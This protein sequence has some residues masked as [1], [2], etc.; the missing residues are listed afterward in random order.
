MQLGARCPFQRTRL[1]YDRTF[2]LE[3]GYCYDH[4]IPY[5]EY[6]ER[7]TDADRARVAAVG[8]ERARICSKCGT[9]SMDWE[10]DPY[11]Y[12]PMFVTC[13]GCQKIEALSKDDTPRPL[14]TS[15]RLV[16]KETAVRLAREAEA[17]RP[18]PRRKRR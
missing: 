2:A 11:A 14:G 7:W 4:G 15:I 18:R 3:V 9:D 13:P 8:L 10:D 5:S 1:R 12:A 6:L 16:P 17:G